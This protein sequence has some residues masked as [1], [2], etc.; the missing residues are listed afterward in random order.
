MSRIL[1]LAEDERAQGTVAVV[2]EPWA[3]Q[4]VNLGRA[5]LMWELEDSQSRF[6]AYMLS[7]G[8]QTLVGILA[9][10]GADRVSTAWLLDGE[11]DVTGSSTTSAQQDPVDDLADQ[12]RE[13]CELASAFMYT[14]LIGLLCRTPNCEALDRALSGPLAKQSCKKG[15]RT[16][17]Y[18]EETTAYPTLTPGIE[19]RRWNDGTYVF[20]NY[21]EPFECL[22]PGS[23]PEYFGCYTWTFGGAIVPNQPVLGL[24]YKWPDGDEE[25]LGATGTLLRIYPDIVQR[26]ISSTAT[27]TAAL[28]LESLED[29]RG[30]TASNGSAYAV[31]EP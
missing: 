28:R 21:V 15:T 1:E 31:Y 27:G 14:L 4:I 11:G 16:H 10:R 6:V 30:I 23:G 26:T 13:E 8:S 17:W 5:L 24:Y 7:D 22:P 20:D 29:V 19:I 25:R 12:I 9:Q 3:A 18:S 2:G